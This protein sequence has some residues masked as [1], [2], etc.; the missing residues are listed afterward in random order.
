MTDS[1]PLA[2]ETTRFF[3][4]VCR[5]MCPTNNNHRDLKQREKIT[6]F[7]ESTTHLEEEAISHSDM[8]NEIPIYSTNYEVR[9]YH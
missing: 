3:R 4:I 1:K 2:K 5:I 8:I 6:H 9:V 7:R